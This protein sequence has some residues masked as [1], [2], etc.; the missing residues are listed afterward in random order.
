MHTNQGLLEEIARSTG[1]RAF[2]PE[3]EK[4][5]RKAFDRVRAEL[6]S[7]YRMG[8]VPS[9]SEG[10]ASRWRE[11]QVELPRRPDLT[12]RSRLGYYRHSQ[13]AP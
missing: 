13:P 10:G 3:K 5:M 1:G 12:V 7:Q 9:R 6:H 11:I 4:E 2:F 8:Y